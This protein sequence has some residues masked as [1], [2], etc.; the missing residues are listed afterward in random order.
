MANLPNQDGLFAYFRRRLLQIPPFAAPTSP[1]TILLIGANSGI[2]LAAAKILLSLQGL[3]N[4]L[5]TARSTEKS[6]QTRQHLAHLCPASVNI[7]TFEVDLADCNSISEF[8]M[9]LNASSK[10]GM[11]HVNTAILN[12]GVMPDTYELGCGRFELT[13][14]VNY[15]S[16][17]LLSLLLLPNLRLGSITSSSPSRLSIC[18]SDGHYFAIPIST[19]YNSENG[20]LGHLNEPSNFSHRTY[21]TSKLLGILFGRALSEK[22]DPAEVLVTIVNPGIAR[23][24]LFRDLGWPY[25]IFMRLFGRNVHAAAQVVVQGALG[26]SGAVHGGFYSEGR[27]TKP[28]SEVFSERGRELQERL[29]SE[30]LDLL[31]AEYEGSASA[32][33]QVHTVC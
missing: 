20:I 30:T 21:P 6:L 19:L 25:R 11:R 31:R 10:S 16:T 15:I 26:G 29:W 9:S 14:Q 1:S 28:L 5:L 12:A 23:T 3:E 7:E 13:L 27:D 32:P 33:S 4:L 2:G 17:A 22:L 24:K 8:I 18:S